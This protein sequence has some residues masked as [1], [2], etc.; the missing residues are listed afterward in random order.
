MNAFVK[1]N[2]A[3]SSYFLKK[4]NLVNLTHFHVNDRHIVANGHFL[5]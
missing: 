1:I 3:H 5:T 2:Y 4:G